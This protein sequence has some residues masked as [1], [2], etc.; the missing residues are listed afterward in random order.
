MNT[1]K[2]GDFVAFNYGALEC[3]RTLFGT[4]TKIV[5]C[6]T[7][8]VSNV[9]TQACAPFVGRLEVNIGNVVNRFDNN[10]SDWG[11]NNSEV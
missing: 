6:D 7:V 11:S 10:T 2:R 5:A 3:E 1:I 9:I 8:Q 4:V